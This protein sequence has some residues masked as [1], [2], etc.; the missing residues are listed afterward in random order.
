MNGKNQELD[1]TPDPRVLQMLGEINLQQ[2]RCLAELIDNS[3]DGFMNS[4]RA[5]KAIANPEVSISIPTRDDETARVSVKDNGPGMSIDQLE[6]AARAGWTGNDPLSSLGLFGMGF[7]ISTARLGLVTEVWTT[8]A[9]DPEYVGI[10]I[11]LDEL[12]SSRSFRVP[13]QSRPKADH[14]EHSTE[15]VIS[16]LKPDQRAYLARANNVKTIRK[17]LARA[18]S[19]L[20]QGVEIENLRL[21]LNGTR[22]EPRRHCVWSEARTV[23]LADGSVVR[24]VEKINVNLAPRRYCLRCMRMLPADGTPCPSGSPSCRVIETPRRIRGW[25]GLQRYLDET[26]Y[27]IDFVRNGRKIEI[28]NKD[29]FLWSDGESS[30]VEYPIDDPRNRGRFVGEIHID[31]CRVS[32]TKDRFERDDP[33]WDE[34]VRLVRGDGPLQPVK[35]KQR[36][37][38]ENASPLFRLFQAFRRSSPQGKNGLWSR[39]MVVKDNERA[40][41]MAELFATNDPEYL[42]DDR[43]WQL[44]EEQDREILGDTGGS[45]GDGGS[46]GGEVP[47]GFLDEKK[48]SDPPREGDA[49]SSSSVE[50]QRVPRQPLHELT[51]KYVHPTYRVE[52]EVQGFSA[53]PADVD[54]P[55]G[56]PWN[57]KMEDVAT[58][59]YF[60]LVDVD[61]EVFRSTTMTPLD[62]LLSELAYRTVDFLKTQVQD[63]SFAKILADFRG[64]Y[65]NDSRLDSREI[66]S[67]ATANLRDIARAV[68]ERMPAGKCEQLFAELGDQEK[69][70]ITR[71]MASRGVPDHKAVIA[72]GRFLEYAEP[73]SI[74]GFFNRHPELFF[75]G[76][77]WDDAFKALDFGSAAVNAEARDRVRSRYDAY[78][79]DAVW[80]AD[81]APND[82]ERVD[83][84]ALVRATC[85]LRLLRPD[86]TL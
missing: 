63:A 85:S 53:D 34:M 21:R 38:G 18:Y 11:D 84:D 81:Q 10:R 40:R 36:G 70:V 67:L 48:V 50:P 78:L 60:F 86:V 20:L 66:I 71:R 47:P 13:R 65:C 29:L 28:G 7:N 17:H 73:Q 8:R 79:V 46:G 24:S 45:A 55:A 58:R 44:V 19:S 62:A 75:D 52:Y 54:L 42:T 14:A 12:R 22:I 49:G 27:G 23:E 25:I 2:W 31:H 77:Y 61:N 33:A 9:G 83:R 15:I 26:E 56:S 4:A 41:Q 43:W 68:A 82:L 51:R 59:T 72:E 37:Y 6:M 69:A 1:L 76:C 16:R 80:L 32:Y 74:R 35:A 57:L 39:V 5:G 64:A 3:I 30:E